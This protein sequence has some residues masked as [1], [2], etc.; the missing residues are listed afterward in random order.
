MDDGFSR[1]EQDHRKIEEQLQELLRDVEAPVVRDLAEQLTHH[2]RVEEMAFYPALRRYVDGGDDLADRAAQEHTTIA[3]M[4]AE[5][6]D[7][8]TPERLADLLGALGSAVRE[9]VEFEETELFPAM[10]SCRVDPAQLAADLEA[11]EARAQ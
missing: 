4:V 11:G 2:A 6:S 8:A 5:L 9:H 7:S 1:L 10:R 3:T